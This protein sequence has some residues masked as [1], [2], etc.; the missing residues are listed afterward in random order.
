VQEVNSVQEI[1]N[2]INTNTFVCLYFSTQ[3]CSVCKVL[4]PKVEEMVKEFPG[5]II[6]YVD[7]EKIEE[8]KGKYFVFTIP[9]ILMF[10]K[11]KEYI[12]EARYISVEELQEKMFRYYNL[13]NME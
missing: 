9:T 10:I 11:G 13:Y 6:K 8:A 5:V 12:R 4:K 2:L 7:I 3:D 1:E